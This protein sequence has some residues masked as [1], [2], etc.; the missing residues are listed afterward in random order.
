[1]TK[2]VIPTMDVADLFY[3]EP[4]SMKFDL[5]EGSEWR[6]KL[7][8]PSRDEPVEVRLSTGKVVRTQSTFLRFLRVLAEELGATE[9]QSH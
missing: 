6:R 2:T 1:M 4:H 9:P 8:T 3:G 7:D 5:F